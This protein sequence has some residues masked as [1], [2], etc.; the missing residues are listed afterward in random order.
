[1]NAPRFIR[2]VFGM[3]D[4]PPIEEAVRAVREAEMPWISE[5]AFADFAKFPE[6]Q[7]TDVKEPQHAH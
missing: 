4:L 1:M 6:I 7:G 5:E 3:D 2:W